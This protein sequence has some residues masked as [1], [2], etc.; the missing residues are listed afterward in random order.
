[1]PA[2]L[3]DSRRWAD[4]G[5]PQ[6]DI[7]VVSGDLIQGVSMD[8]SEADREIE[9]Q[10]EEAGEFLGE[11]TRK[12]F[13][14][15]LSRVVMVPGNHDVQWNRAKQAMRPLESP[16]P[17]IA[18]S[19]LD[20]ESG[21]RWNWRELQAY[22]I[23]DGGR[24]ESRF[25]HFRRFQASFYAD[26]EPNPI[27][28]GTSD[29]VFVEYPT[30]D[31]AVAGFASWHGN[32]CFCHVGAIHP[33]SLAR[34]RDLLDESRSRF[35]VAV[36]HHG[37]VG[38][39][40]AQDYMDQRVIHR[41]IDSGFTIGL[42]GHQHFPGAAPFD[43]RLPNLTSMAVIGAGSLAVGDLE[44]PMGERR[45]Y[46]IV[47]IDEENHV[48]RTHIRS[49]SSAGVFTK[50]HRDDFGG[51]DFMELPLHESPV[52]PK[53]TTELR[54]L[55]D[56]MAAVQREEHVQALSLLTPSVRASYPIKARQITILALEGSGQMDALVACLDPPQ[57]AEEVMRAVSVLLDMREFD[58]ALER[59]E[60]GRS[61]ITQSQYMELTQLIAARRQVS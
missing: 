3:N 20:P 31:L 30:F 61:L 18:K 4:D 34:A 9:T 41:L 21:V 56:A 15:D 36:W 46:N 8:A 58:V 44:L 45:Q 17:E 54:K 26:L 42:H 35:G 12:L 16:P 57:S 40:R 27:V 13:S 55:D 59:L 23:C 53:G 6:P 11:L 25:D 29:L 10:Y 38:G 49:M 51:R 22:E 60:R 14:S 43:L 48:V 52:R 7:L 37:I 32:D 24:Y 2:I 33:S 47:V 19:T 50:S 28:E 5:I 39:P 1:M